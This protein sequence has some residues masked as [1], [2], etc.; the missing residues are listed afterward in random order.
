[1]PIKNILIYY[2]IINLIAF[3]I[4]GVDK[5]R[6][7]QQQWRIPEKWLFFFAFIGGAL[8]SLTGLVLFR[9]KIRKPAFW[10]F[11]TLFA[12]LHIMLFIYLF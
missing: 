2:I 3:F 10:L 5:R 4:W 7:I 8:G 9:H 6:A 11:C 1:M 12:G